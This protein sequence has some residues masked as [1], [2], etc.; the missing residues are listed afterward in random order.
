MPAAVLTPS[1]SSDLVGFNLQNTGA[2][3]LAANSITFGQVFSQG[4]VRPGTTLTATSSSDTVAVQMNALAL[5]DDGSIRLAAITV[6]YATL[7]SG[8]TRRFMLTKTPYTKASNVSLG[9]LAPQLTVDVSVQTKTG[10]I[11]K[12]LDFG[13]A[14]KDQLRAKTADF[15]IRGPLVSQARVDLPVT[16]ALH[17]TAD[18]SGFADGTVTADVQFNN[19]LAMGTSGGAV[20]VTATI[21]LNGA[22]TTLAPVSQKQYQDWHVVVGRSDA[23]LNV[24]HDVAYLERAGAILPYDL[25]TGVAASTLQGYSSIANAAGFGK[26]LNPNGVNQYMPTTGGRGDIGYTTQYNTVWLLTQDMRAAK[27]ALAQSDAAGAVPWNMKLANGH[28]LTPGDYPKI[29]TD[30]RGGPN[31]G[32]T[33]LTQSVSYPVAGWTPDLAHQ[34]NLSYIPY[35]LT[36]TRWNLDRLNAQAAFALSYDWPDPRCSIASCDLVLNQSD[37]VRQ[38]AWSMREIVEAGWIGRPGTFEQGYFSQAATNNWTS[39]LTQAPSMSQKQGE[40][41]GWVDGDYRDPGVTAEWQEDYLSGVITL[42]AEMG[43]A[44]ALS[45]ASWQRTWLA[46]RFMGNGMNPYDGC[47]YNLRTMTTGGTPYP[48][49]AQIEAATKA[50]GNSNGTGWGSSNGDYCAL[51]R[52]ALGGALTLFPTDANLRKALTW[53][54]GAKA[55]YTD[56][57]SFQA[58]PTYNVVP[59]N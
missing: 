16:N 9:R 7:V 22:V 27:V 59:L 33:G 54:N 55:P 18:V 37:Q 36:A 35:M 41:A 23:A 24:Q 29:W 15:W 25:T 2:S 30:Y 19:D 48:T 46:G 14:L 52:S 20:T 11:S 57:A 17:V 13:A 5:H 10:T 31:S 8:E 39:L 38:Q 47:T 1:G 6:P 44:N 43:D 50:S 26:P 32:T 42:A 58:D 45:V 21:T 56:Q 3:T 49:W 51:A 34:P 40:A 4:A 53:L 12:T 28:W